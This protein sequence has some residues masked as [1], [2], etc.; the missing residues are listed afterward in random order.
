[1]DVPGALDLGQHD[2]IELVADGGDDLDDVVERPGRIERIDAGPQS[3][4][5]VVVRRAHLD[6]AAPRR[7]LGVGRNGVLQI[8]ENDV[9]LTDE[10]RNLLAQLLQV[11][12]HEM[13]HAFEPDRQ[14]AQRC[15]RP[16]GERLEELTRKFHRRSRVGELFKRLV[17]RIWWAKPQ[18]ASLHGKVDGGSGN[19]QPVPV[20][21]MIATDHL[22]RWRLRP[23][24]PGESD[25]RSMGG[26]NGDRL[27]TP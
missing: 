20:T 12:R 15:G 7:F 17:E 23:M 26:R 19:R 11:R 25:R 2:H 16:D 18:K 21:D 14:V 10:I 13:D 6:E 22:S 1:M 24:I 3:G 27:W 8:A 5:A 9:D 4:R